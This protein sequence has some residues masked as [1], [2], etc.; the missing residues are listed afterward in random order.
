MSLAQKMLEQAR[1]KD[2]LHGPVFA[3]AV[4]GKWSE[5]EHQQALIRWAADQARYL[6]ELNL[7][8]H[9]PNGGSRAQV[10][11]KDGRRVSVEGA[12]MKAEGVRSG[13]P[14]LVLD[15]PRGEFHGLRIELKSMSGS[16][17]ARQC[18]WLLALRE[19]GYC[20]DCVRGWRD[21]RVLLLEYL[22]GETPPTRWTPGERTPVVTP[23]LMEALL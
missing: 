21:A 20:A 6:P 4:E 14:D 22:T 10:V 3:A 2:A 15:V 16:P 18:G 19:Q 13:Y 11:K 7:L 9:V 1:R 17:S 8:T 23:V 5:S 12:R